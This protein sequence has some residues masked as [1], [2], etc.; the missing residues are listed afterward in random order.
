M[1]RK[2]LGAA[3]TILMALGLFLPVLS[4]EGTGLAAEKLRFATALKRSP[5]YILPALAAE[6]KGFWKEQ[7]LETTWVAFD[8]GAAMHRAV[9]AEHI[10]IGLSATLSVIQAVERGIPEIIVADMQALEDFLVWVRTDS[11]IKAPKDLKGARMAVSRLGGASHAYARFVVKALGMEKDIKIVAA[12]GVAENLA[13]LRAGAVDA[14]MNSPFEFLGLK[15]RGVVR[16]LL[17][18][19][20]Y[21]PKEWIDVVLFSRK[22]V[23]EK[24]PELVKRGVKAVLQS[25]D[26]VMRNRPWAIEKMVA[27][28]G[29][30]EDVA[31]LTY[32]EALRYGADGKID[33]KGMENVVNFL[34]EYGIIARD[35]TPP[36]EQLYTQKFAE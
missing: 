17:A 14:S 12:G 36:M 21:L 3:L 30:S 22:E 9:A 23:A 4:L 33:K 13:S 32:D 26:F 28:S 1:T 18:V 31:R 20:G 6:E 7:G 24:R 10:D 11:P 19:R 2:K 27:H 25:G 29:Y 34:I 5:L 16:D 15:L 8:A 35:K